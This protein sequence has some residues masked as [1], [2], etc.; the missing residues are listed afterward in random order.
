LVPL[1][2][3][4]VSIAFASLLIVGL[5]SLGLAAWLISTLPRQG[6]ATW[7]QELDRSIPLGSLYVAQTRDA[8]WA[9]IAQLQSELESIRKELATVTAA[10]AE[11][12]LMPQYDPSFALDTPPLALIL[13]APVYQQEHSLSCESSAAAMAANYYKVDLS[14]ETIL[15]SLPRHD[16]PHLGFR[17]N[18]DGAYGGVIDYGVYAEP[19]RRVLVDWGLQ[20]E[21]LV[22]GM[23]E[24]RAQIRQ[25]R[26]I[27]AWI[28][29]DLQVQSPTQV[30]TSNGQV[31]TLVPYEHTVLVTG[32]NG[33]G[34]W[35]NDP[36]SGERTF[37]PEQDFARS[38][39]YLGNM[40][41]VVGPPSTS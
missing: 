28:T 41:L 16:N 40:G 21:H 3:D 31:V 19:I 34:L 39:S 4:A 6:A 12:T 11:P 14:E 26:V 32:Y 8:Q 2:L 29:Y 23:D 25:G 30:T 36:Y 17:G 1:K 33:S 22:G 37:Y 5:I 15:A 10:S 7:G 18:V 20:A 38:F 27:I 9:Q 24:I 35:V 13:N